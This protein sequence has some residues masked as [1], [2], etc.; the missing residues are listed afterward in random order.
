MERNGWLRAL[1]ILLVIIAGLYLAGQVWQAVSRFGD[2]VLLFALAWLMAFIL[3]PMVD[4]LS[5]RPMPGGVV[6]LARRRLGD[7]PANLL[8][9]IYLPHWLAVSLVYLSLLILLI[10]FTISLVP[11]TIEQFSQLRAALPYY[12]ER[13][14]GFL[15]A[16]QEELARFHIQLDLVSIYEPENLNR[17]LQALATEMVH[18]A[19][20]IAAGIANTVTSLLF[21]LV[22]SFYMS[23]EGR[24]VGQQALALVPLE[25]Q[26]E[27]AFALRVA[28]RNFGG[29][30]RGSIVMAVLYALGV[31]VVMR[32][33]HLPFT[34]VVAVAS[35]LFTLI[36]VAGHPVSLALPT[37]IALFQNTNTALLVLLILVI[38]QQVFLT[39]VLVPRILSEATG[40]P[41][42]LVL[43]GML[44][45]VRII[46]FWGLIF[47][48]PVAGIIYTM[49]ILFL[50]R[51]KR[52]WDERYKQ[53]RA[54][55]TS[56]EEMG[57][58][59]SAQKS[60]GE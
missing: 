42:L 53:A 25:Y 17:Q 29:F 35:G 50:E 40:M 46:G 47:G 49:G 54:E 11:V 16:T 1:I 27:V 28:D 4:W 8:G 6:R 22:F 14:P 52:G 51:F 39:Q 36:P 41:V 3:R 5:E 32:M 57:E 55:K 21:L 7:R 33:T 38:Y 26:D 30:V 2:I 45:S 13:V 37:L 60:Q 9:R 12:L 56:D 31:V 10:V 34:L 44:V 20:A 48:I 18:N 24:R 23:L 43:A 15:E 58:T 19:G 59:S